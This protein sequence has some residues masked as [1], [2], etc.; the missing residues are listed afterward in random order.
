[1][2][3]DTTQL[4]A[5]AAALGWASG[6]RLYLVVFLTGVA[7][8]LGWVDLPAGLKLLEHPA[9]LAASGFM[10][11]VEFFA[12]KIVWLT[13]ILERRGSVDLLE[14]IAGDP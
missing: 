10:C 6:L 13:E 7:G 14:L 12:D 3:L 8:W 4:L 5:I 9:L 2:D 11:F 1:M